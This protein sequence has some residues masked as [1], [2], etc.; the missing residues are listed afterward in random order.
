M[1][2]FVSRLGTLSGKPIMLKDH[3]SRL[4]LSIISRIVL[5]KKYFSESKHETSIVTLEE[6]Q[7]MLD[8]RM[9][10]LKKKVDR[11]YDHVFDEHKAKKERVKHFVP[12]DMVDLLLQLSD[13]PDLDVRLT[14]EGVKGFT[15]CPI[16]F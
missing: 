7:E 14:Y 11:F 5:G 8:E 1:R 2:A 15:Q 16:L 9:K 10:A 6:F 3:L 12:K 13:D 4:T